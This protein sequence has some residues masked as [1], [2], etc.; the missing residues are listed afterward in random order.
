MDQRARVSPLGEAVMSRA[1]QPQGVDRNGAEHRQ[2]L[3]A[4]GRPSEAG[5]WTAPEGGLVGRQSAASLLRG[6]GNGAICACP[7]A[8]GSA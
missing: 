8:L 3:E 7:G 1:H 2:Y 6:T 4:R 5:G